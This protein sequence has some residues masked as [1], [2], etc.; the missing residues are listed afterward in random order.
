MHL[1]NESSGSGMGKKST[2]TSIEI[3]SLT[4]DLVA[5][6]TSRFE[7]HNIRV[8]TDLP[9]V[10]A[11]VFPE[12]I[13]RAVANLI[14]NAIDSMPSGG[15]LLVTLV[16]CRHQW[17]LEIADTRSADVLP[18]TEPDFNPENEPIRLQGMCVQEHLEIA[19]SAAMIHGGQVQ[20]W[21]CPQGGT[22]NVLVIP[23][24]AV[25]KAG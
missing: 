18:P 23:R 13:H 11:D 5:S 6:F 16:D 7:Q 12:A 2:K 8:E 22:A 4:K 24:F 3:N 25:R 17:E 20:T 15:E 19:N 1:K 14:E 9:N 21:E 10:T